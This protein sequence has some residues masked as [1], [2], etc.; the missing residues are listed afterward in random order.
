MDTWEQRKIRN[1]VFYGTLIKDM[2]K[3]LIVRAPYCIVNKSSLNFEVKIIE[4]LQKSVRSKFRVQKGEIMGLDQQF[5]RNHSI[6]V[7]IAREGH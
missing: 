4:T 2:R 6:Q 1:R 7:R 5:Y 3:F